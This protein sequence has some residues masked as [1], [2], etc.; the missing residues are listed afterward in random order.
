M[1]LSYQTIRTER[2]WRSTTGLSES[3]FFELSSLF[4]EKYD[5]FFNETL[6]EKIKN[7][8]SEV[9]F[10]SYEDLLFFGLYSLKSGLT[11]DI[12][13]FNFGL[14]SS[15]AYENLS[16][17]LAVLERCLTDASCM[18]KRSFENELAFK[19]YLSNEMD[20]LIDVTEQRTQRTVNQSDDYS[21]K[22]NAIPPK[23]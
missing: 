3:K 14:S 7:S 23:P 18:P 19:N 11:Y 4:Q 16:V 12:L 2:L 5:S 20:L 9:A 13:G 6:E 8:R 22:K 21:G 17:V 10:K 15:N 1:S